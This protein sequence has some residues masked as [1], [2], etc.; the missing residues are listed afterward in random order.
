MDVDPE[1][2]QALQELKDEGLIEWTGEMRNGQ[3]VYAITAKG[4]VLSV[5]NEKET[6]DD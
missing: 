1:I 4:I 5:L 6:R 2:N 3:K